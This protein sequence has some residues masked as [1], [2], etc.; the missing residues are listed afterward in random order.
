MPL[1]LQKDT[2]NSSRTSCIGIDH[3][4]RDTLDLPSDSKS[5]QAPCEC[6]GSKNLQVFQSVHIF[7][8]GHYQCGVCHSVSSIT[9][10]S[11]D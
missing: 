11:R 1:L 10:R 4:I 9:Q 8:F 3:G 6:D 7:D 2:V 5:A